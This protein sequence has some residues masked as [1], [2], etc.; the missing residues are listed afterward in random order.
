MRKSPL[1]EGLRWVCQ[2]EE[3]LRWTRHLAHQGAYDLA[4]FFAQQVTEEALKGVLYTRGEE[5][6]LGHSVQR[7]CGRGAAHAPEVDVRGRSWSILDGYDMPPLSQR[8]T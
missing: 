6:V 4:C 8:P 3:D 5:I 2:A 1:E 7:L